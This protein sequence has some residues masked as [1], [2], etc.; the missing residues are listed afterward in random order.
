MSTIAFRFNISKKEGFGHFS[1]CTAI[2]QQLNNNYKFKIHFIVNKNIPQAL[3]KNF[4][5]ISIISLNNKK[6]Y[7]KKKHL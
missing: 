2:A 6:T 3:L 7:L 5:N 4:K 1:R